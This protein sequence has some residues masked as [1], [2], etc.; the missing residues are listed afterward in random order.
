MEDNT[1]IFWD[2]K[3][4]TEESKKI[5]RDELNPR[6]IEFASLLLARTNKPK[7]VFSNYLT[8]ETFV[9][10]W[11]KIKHRMR[12]NRW[13]DRR[14]IFWNEIYRVVKKNKN[15]KGFRG[16][17]ERPLRV[18]ADIKK[19]CDQIR[20]TRQK[21]GLTQIELAKKAGLSQQSISFVEQGYINISIR[22]LKKITDALNLKIVL[23]G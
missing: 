13:N 14:I 12:E 15:I 3:I 11:A 19:I 8:Q 22:T 2:K 23:E 21:I 20:A 6:F 4:N 16:L 1:T 18:D 5:L 10:N 17:K 9:N 7:R